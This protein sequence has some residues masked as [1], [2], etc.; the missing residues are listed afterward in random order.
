ML[1]NLQIIAC[2][3]YLLDL[4]NMTIMLDEQPFILTRLTNNVTL[5][6]GGVESSFHFEAGLTDSQVF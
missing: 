1:I 2:L 6:K 4:M 5:S 3:Y